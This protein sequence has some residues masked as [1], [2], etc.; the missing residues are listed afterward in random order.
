[1]SD[2]ERHSKAASPS[3]I[4]DPIEEARRESENAVAQFDRVLDMIDDV[5]R[6]GRPFRLR[7]SMMLDLHRLALD[8]LSSYAGNFRPSDVEIGQSIISSGGWPRRSSPRM[9]SCMILL[10]SIRLRLPDVSFG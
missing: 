3:L 1:M 5:T 6:S 4:T 7:P 2:G 9:M 8:G 10:A